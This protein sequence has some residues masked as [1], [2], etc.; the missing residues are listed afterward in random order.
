MALSFALALLL[1]GAHQQSAPG[2]LRLQVSARHI[3]VRRSF[4]VPVRVAP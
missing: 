3:A 4:F 1:L 2:Y